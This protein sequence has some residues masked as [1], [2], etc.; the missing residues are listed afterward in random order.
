MTNSEATAYPHA[1]KPEYQYNYP[2]LTKR[3]LFAMSAMQSLI[4]RSQ[5]ADSRDTAHWAIIY[6]DA[7]LAE[8]AVTGE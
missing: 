6:A 1:H 4:S 3:E 7:L 2:G 8:L 5:L